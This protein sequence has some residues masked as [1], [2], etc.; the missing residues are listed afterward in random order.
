MK[1]PQIIKAPW[2]KFSWW[3]LLVVFMSM[4]I[5]QRYDALIGGIATMAD[6][7][8]FLV[9]ISL[10][11]APLFREV[12]VF[13]VNLK[14][15]ID[16]LRAETR[17]QVLNLRSDVQNSISLRADINPQINVWPVPSG[18]MLNSI[19]GQIQDMSKEY[20]QSQLVGR[21]Q[22]VSEQI[23]VSETAK[24]AF[25][26]R[27]AIVKELNRIAGLEWVVWTLKP[28]RGIYSTLLFLRR[29]KL[30]TDQVYDALMAVIS[31]CDKAI[32]GEE[33]SKNQGDFIESVAPI[34]LEK[35]RDI[36]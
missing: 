19:K 18:T 16:S 3:L 7:V 21:P 23:E 5:A 26:I 31:I 20:S 15:E 34:L 17:E 10:L 9:W 1:F 33:L 14:K 11:L 13:G 8:V 22:T 32:H 6:V 29:Q 12:S 25:S 27:Y 28:L 24:L 4:L 30:I 2:A 35:L 36:E